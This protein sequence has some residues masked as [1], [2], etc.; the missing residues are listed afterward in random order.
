MR[1]IEVWFPSLPK[2]S[3]SPNRRV[4]H[5]ERSDAAHE[6]R[7]DVATH[8]LGHEAILGI[9]QP[10]RYSRVSVLWKLTNKRPS[11][12]D[13]PR[14]KDWAIE[15]A[16]SK[17]ERCMCYRPADPF[18]AIDSL[19]PFFDGITDAGIWEDDTWEHVEVGRFARQLVGALSDEGL[20]VEIEELP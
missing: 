14:C 15:H 17:R 18:N 9:T 5:M 20:W 1:Q 19:K 8:L 4:H 3:L 10:L 12:W 7:A 6:L 13:C 16:K 11:I 2:R